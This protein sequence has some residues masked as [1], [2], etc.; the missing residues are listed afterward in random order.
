MFTFVRY[1]SKHLVVTLVILALL[2]VSFFALQQQKA[3]PY[4]TVQVKRGEVIQEVSV[5]GRVSSDTEVDL[6]FEKAGRVIT[7]PRAVGEHVTKDAILVRL[8]ASELEASRAQAQANLAYEEANLAELERGARAEDIAISKAQVESASGALSDAR[9]SVFDRLH[10]A[11]TVADDAIRNKSEQFY[12]NPKTANPALSITISD[13]RLESELEQECVTLENLLVSWGSD[14]NSLNDTSPVRSAVSKTEDALGQIKSYLEQLAL[15]VNGLQPSSR[16]PQATIDGWKLDVSTARTNISV[17]I[18][19]VL[20]ADQAYKAADAALRIAQNELSLKQAGATPEALAAQEAKIV[21]VRATIDNY[22][23]QIAKT[24]LLAPFS[25]VVTKED[26]KL[27]ETVTANIPVVSLMSDGKFKIEATVPEVDV[28]KITLHDTAQVML[29]AYSEVVFPAT[30][31]MIDPA[32]TIIEG[33]STYKVT[34]H[35]DKNEG[36]RIR[37]GMTAN[38]DILT[39]KKEGALVVPSRAVST[40]EGKKFVQVLDG[41]IPR[42]V[43]VELGL[44]G[45]DGSIEVLSGLSEG[46]QVIT[47]K[48][49]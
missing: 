22:N 45:S 43:E 14:T 5:T 34:L 10:V 36:D 40:K 25:G 12:S 19:S 33:V 2:G 3:S 16:T 6:A 27:G 1:I 48:R 13:S 15:A 44:H 46:Q 20:A 26:A 23:A 24:V 42:D 21:A 35:F 49:K 30:V 41:G 18:S 9:K 39:N 11:Y 17:A 28:A 47:F 4:E 31:T 32:E 38:I 8:D 37:S 7:T 29:D